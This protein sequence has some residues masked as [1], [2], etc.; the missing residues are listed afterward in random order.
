MRISRMR[1]LVTAGS[2]AVLGTVAGV[3]SAVSVAG[4]DTTPVTV[5][6]TFASGSVGAAYSGGSISATGGSGTYKFTVTGLPP[7]TKFT[8]GRVTGKPTTVGDYSVTVTAT[9][10]SKPTELTGSATGT[11]VVEQGQPTMTLMTHMAKASLTSNETLTT[12]LH[13]TAKGQPDTGAVTFT[14]NGDPITCATTVVTVDKTKCTFAAS[15]LGGVGTYAIVA[16]DSGD[17]N[18]D[19]ASAAGQVSVYK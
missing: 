5:N 19:A 3:G 4:A 7:G 2:I 18:Y 15:S 10:T 9:D 1:R 6:A 8:Y 13:G 17:V 14:A 11:F 16:D 12:T